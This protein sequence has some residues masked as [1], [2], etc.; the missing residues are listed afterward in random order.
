MGSA[1]RLITDC[2]DGLEEIVTLVPCDSARRLNTSSIEGA[3]FGTALLRMV[4]GLV[5]LAILRIFLGIL[6][7][8]EDIVRREQDDFCLGEEDKEQ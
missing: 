7:D 1:D 6:K 3:G 5:G 2:D 4:T 8:G